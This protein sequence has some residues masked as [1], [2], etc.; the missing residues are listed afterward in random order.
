MGKSGIQ[1]TNYT[2]NPLT[3]CT[4]VTSGCDNCYAFT[5]HTMRHEAYKK[6]HGI[7]PKTGKLMPA[8]YAK[9]FE[10]I[11]LFPQRLN[12]PLKNKQPSM[13]FVNSMSDLFHSKV[14]FDYLLDCFEVM[15]KADW[16]IFQVLTKRGNRLQRLAP[17]IDWPAN[18]WMGVSIESDKL[19]ARAN[20]LRTVPAAVRFLSCEPLLGPL[21]SLNLDGI[22]WVITGGESGDGARPMQDEWACEIRDRCVK[23]KPRIPYF[24]KQNGGRTPKAGGRLLQGREWDEM[25]V[26]VR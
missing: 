13:Y 15:R 19:T 11:Q 9:P 6:Y 5:L 18:V 17:V 20:Q 22:D 12:D 1:W 2:W 23:H 3:G 16:H 26:V 24:H 25:P 7:Y 21:P 14:P 4:R 8:Q 10:E